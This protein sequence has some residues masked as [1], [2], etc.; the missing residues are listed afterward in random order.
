MHHCDMSGFRNWHAREHAC[1]TKAKH[2]SGRSTTKTTCVSALI[3]LDNCF[4]G[5]RVECLS[6]KRDIELRNPCSA[7]FPST[8]SRRTAEGHPGTQ[9]S[10][11][12]LDTCMADPTRVAPPSVR[13]E[14]ERATEVM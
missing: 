6:S 13:V 7:D 5:G 12:T 11:R 4:I 10:T 14:E 2:H 1:T 3:A 8:T 9:N